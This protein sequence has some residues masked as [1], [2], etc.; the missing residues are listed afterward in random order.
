MIAALALILAGILIALYPRLLVLLVS[1]TL[2][3][4]GLTIQIGRAHV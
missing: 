3:A 2:I 1:G 4:T